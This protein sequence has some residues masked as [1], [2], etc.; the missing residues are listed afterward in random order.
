MFESTWK[1]LQQYQCP[2]WFRDAKFGMWA[3]WGPQSV[4]MVGD[5]YARNMYIE[6]QPQYDHHCRTYGHPSKFGYKDIVQLWKAEH[7]EPERLIDLYKSAGAKYFVSMAIHHDNFDLWNST[8]HAWNSTK[9]GPERDIVG[10]WAKAARAAGLRFGVSE[11]LERTYSWFNTNK[12]SDTTGPYA[13]V[14]YDGN[15]PELSDFYIEKH[16]DTSLCYPD[17]PS[18][19]WPQHWKSRIVDLI[20]QYQPDLLYTD[21]GVPFG[22]VGREMVAHFYNNSVQHSGQLDAVYALKDPQRHE[23]NHG[24]YVDGFATLDVERGVVEGIAEEPWQTDTCLGGWF[25]DSRRPYKTPETVV[26]M[27]ADIVSKNGCLLLNATQRPDGTLDDQGEWTVKEIGKW[28][29]VNGEAIYETRPW[30]QFGEG[31]TTFAT[32]SYAE[33]EE[34]RFTGEDF[35]FTAKSD[36]LYAIAMGKPKDGGWLISS[37]AGEQV[38]NASILGTE[39]TSWRNTPAGLWVESPAKRPCEH[40][41]SIAIKR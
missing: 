25:Y 24:E 10:E 15:D 2:D 36:T 4:P 21:G 31:P 22:E 40:A 9:I 6:G 26:H 38:S 27:L 29:A 19:A 30:K 14:P 20:D 7:W 8:H 41:W 18:D 16:D 28:M 35:R 1:S 37:L 5:W 33:R 32:S 13:G 11:H 23:G 34:R 3:H 39:H 17:N 12:G